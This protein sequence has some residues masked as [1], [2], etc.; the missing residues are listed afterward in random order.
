MSLFKQFIMEDSTEIK[1]TPEKIW[2]FFINLDKNYKSWHPEDHIVFK[3]V[4]G[5]PMTTDSHYYG[6]EYMNG[7]VKKFKGT[8]GEVIPNRKIVFKFT[9]PVTLVSPYF[10]WRIEPKGSNS[11]FTAITIIR[12]EKFYRRIMRKKSWDTLIAT[13]KKHVQEEG[14]NLKKILEK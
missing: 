2:D 4:K 7:R 13:G 3:W 12:C 5:K 11:V 1:T 10:E 8:I 6:E 14:E 9:F